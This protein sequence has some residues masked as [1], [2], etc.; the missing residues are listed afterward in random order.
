MKK[1]DTSPIIA[2]VGYPPSK[3][4]FDF[5]YLSNQ[6]MF[7]ALAQAIGGES[8]SGSEIYVLWGCVKSTVGVNTYA[9]TPGYIYNASG[10]EIYYYPG[11]LSLVAAT[12][13]QLSLD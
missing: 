12:S 11:T 3:K 8:L 10:S 7:A 9:I 2:G 4:G 1:L 6:E 5:L 13:I